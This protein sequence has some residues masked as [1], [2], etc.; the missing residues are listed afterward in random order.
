VKIDFR[1]VQA[2]VVHLYKARFS[3]HLIFRLGDR[4]GA[5][6][7]MGELTPRV[8]MADFDFISTL[9][10]LLNI[11][12]TFNGLAALGVEAALLEELDAVYERG[13][14]PLLLG[15]A[16]GSRSDP[17]N[18][19]EGQFKTDDI[20]CIVHV[21]VRGEDALES[22][23][24]DV[25]EL[26][27]RF[28]LTEL[29][30]RRDGTALDGR[31]LGNAKL[32]FGYTDGI[33]HPDISWDDAPDRRAQVNF[34]TFLLGYSSPEHPSAPARGAAADLVRDSC[35]G[36]FRWIYQDTA[37]FNRF[38]NTEGP[39]VFPHLAPADAE[40]LLAA[41]LMGRWRNG[42]PLVLSPDREDPE[43]T[44][45]DFGYA[46]QDAEGH[47]CPFS[48]HIRVVNPR[49]QQ[50]DPVA[51]RVPQ[52][53]RRG[54]PY[55][56]VLKSKEDDGQDRGI[57]GLFLCADI[58]RQIYTLTGWIRRNDFSP[59]YD[60][61]RRV[62]DAVVGN[63]SVAGTST[64]FIIPGESG[65]VTVKGLPDFV[66][67]KGTAFLLYPAKGTLEKLAQPIAANT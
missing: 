49:D 42:T 5:R 45:N 34:R 57:I 22:A 9:D 50:L 20:H 46:E 7:F 2:T 19:W 47:R 4:D 44:G 63:R 15:D 23:S 67:T 8:T 21:Y 56:P 36:V 66:H 53:I 52:V 39:R 3:R 58:R 29:I 64:D 25:R 18:W 13:P 30:P 14:D 6:A 54:M 24:A 17:A 26:A 35:Y 11:G 41:K 65:A 16:P 48:A 38:L 12:I 43:L 27:R 10:P 60:A 1:G 51:E 59:V 33:S 61:N 32:H 40:E 31:S 55:G 62:Q 28:G 37:T